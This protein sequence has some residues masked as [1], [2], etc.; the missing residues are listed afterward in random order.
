MNSKTIRPIA[1]IALLLFTLAG[2]AWS[3]KE[4]SIPTGTLTLNPSRVKVD[5]RP[6]LDWQIQYPEVAKDIVEITD[7]NQLKAKRR[8]RV[9]VRVAGSPSNLGALISRLPSGQAPGEPGNCC[10]TAPTTKLILK[11]SSSIAFWR[12]IPFSTLQPKE[13]T[14]VAA[15]TP[16]GPPP[17][18]MSPLSHW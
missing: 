3:A 17:R 8:A 10:S 6:T 2:S 15:G 11:P 14:P 4:A 18:A 5:S 1:A 9:Q 16:P 13:R 7:K 12:P